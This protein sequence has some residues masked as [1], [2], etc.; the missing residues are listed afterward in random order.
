V[1]GYI[2]PNGQ[3]VTANIS[4]GHVI[5]SNSATA[6]TDV[7]NAGWILEVA[8]A[9]T[10]GFVLGYEVTGGVLGSTPNGWQVSV[11]IPGITSVA[12]ATLTWTQYS[13]WQMIN[14]VSGVAQMQY[15]AA[16]RHCVTGVSFLFQNLTA[17]LQRGGSIYAAR[18]PGDTYPIPGTV[19]SIIALV[20]SQTHHKL[21]EHDLSKGMHWSYTPEKIQDW[22]FQQR[23]SDDPYSGNPLN[24]P[25][26]V[27]AFNFNGITPGAQPNFSMSGGL[28]LEM[29]TTDVS[30]TFIKSLTCP[31]LYELLC[32]ELSQVP[33]LCENP[34][35][36]KNA[37]ACAKRVVTSDAFKLF[38]KQMVSAGVKLA[39]QLLALL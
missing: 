8:T 24:T 27:M 28:S 32:E 5:A 1:Y 37:L 29:L 23:V 16:E 6:L 10:Q 18:L 4:A 11:Q 22:M 14:D 26:L 34:D 35:H 7:M 30:N 13:L 3:F 15:R 9:G 17:L 31:G 36:L 39:P 2:A 19:Q 12:N 25:F 20:S 33:V 38:A 21:T